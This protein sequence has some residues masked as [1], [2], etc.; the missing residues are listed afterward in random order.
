MA[1]FFQTFSNLT[2]SSSL[3]EQSIH[4]LLSSEAQFRA[5]KS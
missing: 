4:V 5:V 1:L 3:L 2:L